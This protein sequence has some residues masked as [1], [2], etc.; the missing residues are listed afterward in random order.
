[1]STCCGLIRLNLG[2]KIDAASYLAGNSFFVLF[3][4]ILIR[5]RIQDRSQYNKAL[6]RASE[7]Y[8]NHLCSENRAEYPLIGYCVYNRSGVAPLNVRRVIKRLNWFKSPRSKHHVC[9]L[10]KIKHILPT[11]LLGSTLILLEMYKQSFFNSRL[12]YFI[13]IYYLW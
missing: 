6:M 8:K 12:A 1:M 4:R 13:F 9:K 10:N 3:G 5:K 2:N 11:K 7:C